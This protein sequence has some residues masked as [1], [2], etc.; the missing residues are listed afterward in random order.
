MGQSFYPGNMSGR[1][2]A[3]VMVVHHFQTC[4]VAFKVLLKLRE[5]LVWQMPDD[6]LAFE[7]KILDPSD[8][9]TADVVA[10]MTPTKIKQKR[11]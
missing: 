5:V 6:S 10:T 2:K 8:R 7:Y 4:G 1:Q 11:R 3:A 9:V